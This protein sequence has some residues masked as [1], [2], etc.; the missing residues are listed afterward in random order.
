[1]K[2]E[3]VKKQAIKKIRK[4]T[5]LAGLNCDSLSDEELWSIWWNIVKENET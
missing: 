1:M 5:K 3:E 4:Q 2:L